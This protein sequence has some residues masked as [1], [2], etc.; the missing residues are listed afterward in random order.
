MRRRLAARRPRDMDQT[1]KL[2]GYP[3]VDFSISQSQQRVSRLRNERRPE[4]IKAAAAERTQYTTT[5]RWT[6]NSCA[7]LFAHE[8]TLLLPFRS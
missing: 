3:G 1:D 6:F 5:T 7:F 4:A 8:R 2:A